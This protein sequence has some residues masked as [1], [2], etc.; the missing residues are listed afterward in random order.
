MK[1]KQISIAPLFSRRVIIAGSAAILAAAII[2]L[3]QAAFAQNENVDINEL[4]KPGEL[5]EKI[6]GKADAPH[7]IIEYSSLT[8]PHCASFHKNVLPKVKEKYIDTGK[9]K[10]IIREFPLDNVA[11]AGFMLARCVD[12]AKYFDFID[13][14]YANQEEW[15][16][17]NNPL[18]GLQK[19]SKQVGFTEARVTECLQDEKTLNY[20]EWVRNRGSDE[21]GVS[22]TPSFFIDGKPVK[23][24]SLEVFD[25]VLDDANKS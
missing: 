19:F 4:M 23:G 16:F 1:K 14:L 21:F 8:C 6:L 17:Q 15:A 12:D 3:P 9:A 24:N 13:L 25:K 20:I 2:G 5:P 22:A 18:I 7:T 11:A 10:Y